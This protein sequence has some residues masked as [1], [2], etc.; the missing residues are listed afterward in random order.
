MHKQV[1]WVF[2]VCMSGCDGCSVGAQVSVLGAL[3]VHKRVL[4]TCDTPTKQ[5]ESCGAAVGTVTPRCPPP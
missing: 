2:C 5:H 1:H 4:F 3:W